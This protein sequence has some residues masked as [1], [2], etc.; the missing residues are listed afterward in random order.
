[1]HKTLNLFIMVVITTHCVHAM[2]V[3]PSAQQPICYLARLPNEIVSLIEQYLIFIDRETDQQAI[4]RIT[5]YP[6]IESYVYKIYLNNCPSLGTCSNRSIQSYINQ[7]KIILL[8]R[9]DRFY[10]HQ[11]IVTIIDTQNKIGTKNDSIA[12]VVKKDMHKI[13][14]IGLSQNQK[15]FAMILHRKRGGPILTI[16]D[17]HTKDSKKIPLRNLVKNIGEITAVDFNK[18]TTKIV[19]SHKNHKLIIPKE[20]SLLGMDVYEEETS[21]YIMPLV[22]EREHKEKTDMTLNTYFRFH[23]VCNNVAY[24]L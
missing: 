11:P 14:A 8:D 22:S 19:L 5:S 24:S 13:K 20:N 18:Q 17:M 16:T 23:R 21:H 10:V 4:A 6:K 7:S 1:M 9:L 2:E 12:Q 15:M 3:V